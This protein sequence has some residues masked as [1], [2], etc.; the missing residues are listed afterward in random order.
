MPRKKSSS[1]IIKTAIDIFKTNYDPSLAKGTDYP[2]DYRNL[3]WFLP[4]GQVLYKNLDDLTIGDYYYMK[5]DYQISACLNSIT[6]TLKGIDW[7]IECKD[8]K[9]K[10]FV[11]ENLKEIWSETIDGLSQAFWAGYSPMVKIFKI[12]GKGEFK[13]LYK[14]KQVKDLPPANCEVLLDDQTGEFQGFKYNDKEVESQYA[15]WYAFKM[16]HGNYYGTHLLKSA[17]VP[18]FFSQII[19]MFANRYFERF[20]EPIVIGRYPSEEKSISPISGLVEESSATMNTI[21]SRIRN[22]SSLVLSSNKLKD[23]DGKISETYEWDVQYLESQM[24]GADFERYLA[25]LDA[26]KS[27]AIFVPQPELLLSAGKVGSTNL[28]IEQKETFLMFLNSVAQDAKKFIQKYIV[29]KMVEYNF[30]IG[31]KAD[32]T[33][34]SLGKLSESTLRAIITSEIKAGN[35]RVDVEDLADKLGI[36]L[37]EVGELEKDK[38]ISKENK[39][40]LE[41]QGKKAN[42]ESMHKFQEGLKKKL[43]FGEIRSEEKQNMTGADSNLLSI[44]QN[45]AYIKK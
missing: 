4:T 34:E 2:T 25:R 30:G 31:A 19:H 8:K 21:V 35:S 18:Y 27:K 9:I 6:L 43:N 38:N 20:G 42:K 23:D 36:K 40:K 26:E 12:E 15:F 16:Q 29:D 14:I 37:F 1:R 5:D 11:T 44:L 28:G 24:R 13:G 17:Y 45:K 33:F 41:K 39:D 10:D 7:S 32:L 22:H 3:M